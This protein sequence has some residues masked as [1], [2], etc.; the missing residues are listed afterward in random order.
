MNAEFRETYQQGRYR[1]V[2]KPG[3]RNEALDCTVYALTAVDIARLMTGNAATQLPGEDLPNTDD[4]EFTDE[5]KDDIFDLDEILAEEKAKEKSE[6]SKP[7]VKRATR[8]L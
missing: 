1:W 2:C 7:K 6:T 8:K 4:I 5:P 3:V